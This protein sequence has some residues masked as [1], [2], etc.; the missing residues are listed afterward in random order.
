VR[1]LPCEPLIGSLRELD[2]SGI[3]W[4]IVGGGESGPHHRPIEKEWIQAI[5]RSCREQ[6]VAFSFTQCGGAMS[7]SGD[8][9]L[10]GRTYDHVPRLRSAGSTRS[11]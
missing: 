4:V 9:E 2:L 7:K 1:S 8:R 5:R 3:D 10:D 6:R 11:A